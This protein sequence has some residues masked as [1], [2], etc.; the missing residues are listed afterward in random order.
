MTPP[1]T[2][3]ATA[4]APA[5]RQ[6]AAAAEQLLRRLANRQRLLM[7]CLLAD[8]ELSVG[9]INARVALSQSALSQHL[10]QLR[11]AGVVRTRRVAQTIYYRLRDPRVL[12]LL[13]ALCELADSPGVENSGA[14]NPG[15]DSPQ[16]DKA[17]DK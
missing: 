2:Q 16:T 9:E 8:G 15:A 11:A 1:P 4:G 12:A 6:R 17:V 10:A 3:P 7:L 14:G 13:G 5:L